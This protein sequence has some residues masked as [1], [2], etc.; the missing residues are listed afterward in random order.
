MKKKYRLHPLQKDAKLI[1]RNVRDLGGLQVSESTDGLDRYYHIPREVHVPFTYERCE[2]SKCSWPSGRRPLYPCDVIRNFQR[3]HRNLVRTPIPAPVTCEGPL[4]LLD[5]LLQCHCRRCQESRNCDFENNGSIRILAPIERKALAQLL[6]RGNTSQTVHLICN[7]SENRQSTHLAFKQPYDPRMF[8][9]LNLPK[10]PQLWNDFGVPAT[11]NTEDL[12]T[13]VKDE[14]CVTVKKNNE[15]TDNSLSGDGMKA[16][17]RSVNDLNKVGNREEIQGA[18]RA[19]VIESIHPNSR[20]IDEL[21]FI[22]KDN[23]A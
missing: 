19:G 16:E 13:C 9:M 17:G 3:R 2:C 18:K 8:E 20:D 21:Y 15:K 23:L 22:V 1:D 4:D 7:A 5:P 11:S 12:D 6:S 10:P 14:S